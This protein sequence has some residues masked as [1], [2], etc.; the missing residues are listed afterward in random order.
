APG[1]DRP[2][3][4]APDRP[5]TAEPTPEPGGPGWPGVGGVPG[6]ADLR[7]RAEASSAVAALV[8]RGS[9]MLTQA[10]HVREGNASD[11][12]HPAAANGRA[13]EFVTGHPRS[14]YVL[15]LLLDPIDRALE[16]DDGPADGCV[17]ALA[18]H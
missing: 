9:L 7:R 18:A 17:V 12:T 3:D 4:D 2:T 14:F 13:P 5:A 8:G 11:P 10:T 15:D 16:L 6:E 1:V